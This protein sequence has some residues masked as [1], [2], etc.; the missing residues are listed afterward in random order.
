MFAKTNSHAERALNHAL[1]MVTWNKPTNIYLGLS[2]TNP[3]KA[4]SFAG[5]VSMS[6]T[7]YARALLTGKMQMTDPSSGVSRL[8][9][10]LEF[11]APIANWPATPFGFIADD[12]TATGPTNMLYFGAFNVVFQIYA[13]MAPL[14]LIPGQISVRER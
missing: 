13:G 3:T 9:A 8:N 10:V 5:E 2:A 14:T 7:G 6:G 11:G 4:G 1:G 12:P